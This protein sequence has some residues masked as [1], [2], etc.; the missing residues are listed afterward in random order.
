MSVGLMLI[1]IISRW[2]ISEINDTLLA[3]S[4]SNALDQLNI[5]NSSA[6]STTPNQQQDASRHGDPSFLEH[7]LNKWFT[8]SFEQ[9]VLF[10]LVFVLITKYIYDSKENLEEEARAHQQKSNNLNSDKNSSNAMFKFNKKNSETSTSNNNLTSNNQQSARKS[11]SIVITQ[12]E[13]QSIIKALNNQK[14]KTTSP[15]KVRKSSLKNSIPKDSQD[16]PSFFIGADD[17]GSDDVELVDKEVQTE[18]SNLEE[19]LKELSFKDTRVR[20]LDHLVKLLNSEDGLKQLTDQEILLLVEN[21]K[22]RDYELEKIL[23]DPERGVKIRRIFISKKIKNSDAML[24]IPYT[25]YDYSL[26]MGACCENVIGYMPVP[27]G[28][29]GPLLL[30]DH[31]YQIPMATSEGTHTFSILVFRSLT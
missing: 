9:L 29:A 11:P 8:I 17:S 22:I 4:S 1:H 3:N 12:T 24:K 18:E 6:T 27:L 16:Q 14:N 13:S 15:E 19:A 5:I 21:R 20:E 31:P 2:P 10:G 28:I 7:H 25:K 23:D 26:V 30:D